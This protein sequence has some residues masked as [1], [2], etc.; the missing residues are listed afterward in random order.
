MQQEIAD[1]PPV[2]E[3]VDVGSAGYEVAVP[4]LYLGRRPQVGVSDPLYSVGPVVDEAEGPQVPE[5]FKFVPGGDREPRIRSEVVRQVMVSESLWVTKC[6]LMSNASR[7]VFSASGAPG[8]GS[9]SRMRA[10]SKTRSKTRVVVS[11]P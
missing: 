11:S 9:L 8:Y 3:T 5:D 6:I 2:V 1:F 7:N 10:G 4:R